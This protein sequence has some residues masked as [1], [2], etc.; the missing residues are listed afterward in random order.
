MDLGVLSKEDGIKGIGGRV[1]SERVGIH[2]YLGGRRYGSRCMKVHSSRGYKMY[3][4][5]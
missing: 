4:Y 2:A 5:M 3:M 1:K